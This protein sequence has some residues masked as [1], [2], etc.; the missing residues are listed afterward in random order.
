[1][2]AY[3]FITENATTFMYFLSTPLQFANFRKTRMSVQEI[4][5]EMLCVHSKLCRFK[6][7]KHSS[8]NGKFIFRQQFCNVVVIIYRKWLKF[9]QIVGSYFSKIV[10]KK[11]AVSKLF[12]RS[13]RMCY[14][15]QTITHV[16]TSSLCNKIKCETIHNRINV[17]RT[18]LWRKIKD[19]VHLTTSLVS[20]LTFLVACAGARH[21]LVIDSNLWLSISSEDWVTGEHIC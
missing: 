5:T 9:L 2:V 15:V 3:P 17:K 11:G 8:Q 6:I 10:W 18:K 14:T 16:T 4:N 1:M 7:L 19:K 20:T 21:A 13:K 12:I